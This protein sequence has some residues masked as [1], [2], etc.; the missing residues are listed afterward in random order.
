M[1]HRY[2]VLINIMSI[3]FSGMLIFSS[4][5]GVAQCS[6]KSI[7][8]GCKPNVVAPYK[9]DSY[10]IS[11]LKFDKKPKIVEV[12]FT[13]FQGQKYKL[14]FCS[15][16]FEE[17]VKLDIYNK[18]KSVK[19]GRKKLY[20]NSQGIDNNFWTFEPPKSGNYFIDYTIPPSKD[21]TVKTGCVV[22]LVSYV[23]EK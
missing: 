4:H 5:R 23:A 1:S 17:E 3:L 11:E 9:Y 21:G 6:A 15:S 14:V 16:G 18:S 7:M 12:T 2:V 20:D 22:L 8:K 19:N 10:V 13:A